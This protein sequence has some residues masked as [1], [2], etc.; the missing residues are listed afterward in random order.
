MLNLEIALY[1][2]RI[3]KLHAYLEIDS[4]LHTRGIMQSQDC[5]APLH[6]LEI[7]FPSC[8]RQGTYIRSSCSS[9]V[10]INI[11]HVLQPPVPETS[12]KF[13][14]PDKLCSPQSGYGCRETPDLWSAP[15]SRHHHLSKL[16]TLFL[17]VSSDTPHWSVMFANCA[18]A[19]SRLAHSFLI[20]RL[21]SSI[22]RL[23]KFLDCM[24]HMHFV[25]N[26]NLRVRSV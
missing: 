7:E 17:L 6:N 15:R 5:V 8:I 1:F 10:T 12:E 13:A 14:N 25:G 26:S 19:I 2:L 20:L 21:C 3:Q 11:R 9:V 23:L 24:E 18:H 4:R 22:L 16:S